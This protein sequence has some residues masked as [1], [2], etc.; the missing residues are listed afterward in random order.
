[1]PPTSYPKWPLLRPQVQTESSVQQALEH[2]LAATPRTTSFLSG[3]RMRRGD[4]CAASSGSLE[5]FEPNAGA[6]M[7]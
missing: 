4:V 5:N 7:G 2:R 1:M 3:P 6:S